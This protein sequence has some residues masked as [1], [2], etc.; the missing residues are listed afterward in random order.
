MASS[1]AAT[2]LDESFPIAIVDFN[3][4]I[5]SKENL[6]INE[7]SIYDYNRSTGQTFHILPDQNTL[8]H[9]LTTQGHRQI[10]FNKH[11]F[12]KIPLDFGSCELTAFA[13]CLDKLLSKYSAILVKGNEKEDVLSQLCSDGVFKYVFNLDKLGC[14]NLEELRNTY[15]SAQQTFC[16][17]H[18]PHFHGCTALKC[19]VIDRW[20]I[21]NYQATRYFLDRY[22]EQYPDLIK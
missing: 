11:F 1:M 20:L 2:V 14:P 8:Q 7:C 4:S 12:H 18:T 22:N 17:F 19:T 16:I 13:T 6:A 3:F 10:A 5:L 9:A 15:T 21:A